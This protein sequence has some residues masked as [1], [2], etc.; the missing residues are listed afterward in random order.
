[1]I[2]SIK[3]DN[4]KSLVEFECPLAKFNCLIGLNG[5][6]KST[7][8]QAMDFL[9]QLMVGDIDEWLEQR[10]W[11]KADIN[12][13]LTPKSNID[14][15]VVVD[16]PSWGEIIWEGSVNRTK[17]TCTRESIRIGE[18]T[19]LNV[20]DGTVTVSSP[21]STE[22]LD[23][24]ESISEI[25]QLSDVRREERFPIVFEY[26]GSIISQLKASQITTP[27]AA[28]RDQMLAMKSLDLLS[29]S[30]LR[31]KSRSS[32]KDMG[33]GGEKLSAFLYEMTTENKRALLERL[34]K[35][36]PALLSLKTSSLKAGWKQLSITE[37]YN[38]TKLTSEARH[39]NDGMLR[40][41]AI[42]AQTLTG[43]TFLLFDEIENGINPELVE[44]VVQWLVDAPQQIMVTTHSPMILNYLDDETAKAG[45]L[46]VYKTSQGFTKVTPF[47]RIP[48]M[49]AKLRTMGPG[50]VFVDTDLIALAEQIANSVD[51]KG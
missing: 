17:L 14:F 18:H 11:K 5:A 3:I 6:G 13:K 32:D 38:N 2:K 47:F 44:R 27:M 28:V 40:V 19:V 31:K 36:Y 16:H 8:L 1:M 26:Q 50:E 22:S 25:R 51:T 23:Q 46:L 29:P 41:M 4:F 48:D 20:L 39:I 37:Q 10:S 49:E 7:I 42:I 43:H 45:V 9:S 21:D 33:L 34:E 35:L 24:V 15:E 30:A 12:S